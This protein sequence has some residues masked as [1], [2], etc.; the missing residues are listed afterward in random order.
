MDGDGLPDAVSGASGVVL[1]YRNHTYA[2]RSPFL[3]LGHA[4]PGTHGYPV[5]LADGTLLTGEPFAV[6]LLNG[7][8]GGL[9]TIVLGATQADLPFKGG[10]MVPFPTVLLFGNPMDGD[11][12]AA[13]AG[14]WPPGI[15]SGLSIYLQWWFADGGGVA[16][17]AASSGLRL[18]AP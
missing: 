5:Q 3:D 11:G 16:G 2:P 12:T 10:T 13:V 9:A 6:E 18:T 14:H 8:P 4:L 15:P 7:L 17:R 1:T